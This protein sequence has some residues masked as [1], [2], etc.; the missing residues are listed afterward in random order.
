MQR[1]LHWFIGFVEGY[2]SF[3]IPKNKPPQFE[4]TQH[5]DEI[6]LLYKIKSFLKFG[7]VIKRKERSVAVYQVIG[8]YNSLF[9]LAH[10]FNGQLRCPKRGAQFKNWVTQLQEYR[11]F[12]FV[13][14]PKL[15]DVT[16]ND[17]WLSGFTDAEGHFSSRLK[18]C[19]TSKLG[20]Q[21]VLSYAISQK[22][23]DILV[24]IKNCLTL[25]N[26]VMWDK[27]WNGYRISTQSL[28][29]QKII[30]RYFNKFP[31]K[32]KKKINYLKYANLMKDKIN[33][34]HTTEKGLNIVKKKNK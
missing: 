27:S 7:S 2:G 21:L 26:Q 30:V 23:P 9:K 22:T 34:L 14:N 19:K 31:L 17:A 1:N 12:D 28:K 13:Y 6:H 8:N 3:V 15:L 25:D 33:K 11:T 32:T 16:L 20:Q 10:I 5:I 24:K 29:K 4:I 18:P